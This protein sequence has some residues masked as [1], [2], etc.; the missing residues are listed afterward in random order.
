MIINCPISLGE[1]VDKISILK[2]KIKNISDENKVNLAKVEHD[3]LMKTL[4]ELSLKEVSIYLDEL[5][6]INSE[7]WIIEDD[8]REEERKKDFGEKFILLS[9]SVYRT[10]DRRFEVKN[11]INDFYGSGIK[12]VKSYE[13][14]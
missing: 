2:I 5:I 11:R 13:E 9:R 12:E 10:N 1:L 14:Y 4:D 8:I 7:L 6:V 3:Q